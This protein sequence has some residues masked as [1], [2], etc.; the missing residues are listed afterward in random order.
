MTQDILDIT[1]NVPVDLRPTKA[2]YLAMPMPHRRQLVKPLNVDGSHFSIADVSALRAS[3]AERAKL[4]KS[5]K[6]KVIYGKNHTQ[7]SEG[8]RR[9]R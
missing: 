6:A 8:I 3:R 2:Q 7:K 5:R 1:A 9:D 4:K